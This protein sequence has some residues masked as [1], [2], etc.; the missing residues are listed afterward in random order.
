[1]KINK[2]KISKEFKKG[3]PNFSNITASC[4]MEWELGKG[5]AP[6]WPEMWD[7]VNQQLELQAST[8]DQSWISTKKFK[9][10]MTTTIKTPI[11]GENNE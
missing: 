8:M 11:G 5:E 2:I 6:N 3:L 9:N 4:E 7:T 1:M 10:H